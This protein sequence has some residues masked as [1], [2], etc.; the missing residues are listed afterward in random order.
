MRIRGYD[1]ASILKRTGKEI[2]EDKITVYAGQMAYAMFFSLFPL[3]LFFAALLSLVGDQ[4]TVQSWFGS[5]LASALPSDVAGLLGAT[6]EKVIFSTGAPG[7]LSFGLLTAAWAGSGVF[8]ALRDALNAA[9]DVTETRPRWK[10]Y[11]L[12]LGML[13]IA[14][15]V[16]LLSTVILL[17]GEGV[18]SWLGETLHLGRVTTVLWTIVQFPLA[19][20]ALV[21]VIWL[22]YF[23]LPN[24]RGQDKKVLLIGALIATG[25]WIAATMLFRLYVQQFNRMNPAYGAVGAIM[26]L[27]TWMYY[28]AF[29]F[30]AVGELNTVIEREQAGHDA[31]AT[32]PRD[33]A[34]HDAVPRGRALVPA[35]AA[36]RGAPQ[37]RWAAS[38]RTRT[39]GDGRARGIRRVLRSV[40]AF[41]VVDRVQETVAFLR[42]WIEGTLAHLRADV[43]AARREVGAVT[44]G[45]GVGMAFVSMGGVLA[46]L[47]TISLLTG[48]ALLIG[49]QWLPSDLYWL[50]ALVVTVIS[51]AIAI[52]LGRRGQNQLRDGL[53]PPRETIESLREDRAVLAE[54]VRRGR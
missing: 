7:L 40:P 30:L 23:L 41:R 42:D 17:N 6:I 47:G 4:R 16:V 32:R 36:A 51:A 3:L 5:R 44:R 21:A 15:V 12:Q 33:L 25:L 19:I 37:P 18:M 11:A 45:I 22:I 50:G 39:D 29:V 53:A 48:I 31:G 24:C 10:Q 9:Y 26:V 35:A 34:A 14:G 20:G 1:V 28:S 49:D 54:A 27:L 52:R 2:G 46:L 8:G 43:A 38:M 13:G